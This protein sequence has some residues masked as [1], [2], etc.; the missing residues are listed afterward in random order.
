M[1]GNIRSIILGELLNHVF[2]SKYIA[3]ALY[4]D[5]LNQQLIIPQN[6]FPKHTSNA[7]LLGV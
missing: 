4:I 1:H 7:F 3:V 6:F 5:K 2:I